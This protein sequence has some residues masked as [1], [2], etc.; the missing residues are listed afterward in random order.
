[1]HWTN[2]QLNILDFTL[3][4][5][6][7]RKGRNL[8]LFIVYTAVV[9][10]LASVM[11]FTHSIKQEAAVLLKNA[12][13][14]L[15]Q[16]V[17][18]GRHALVPTG[19]LEK[20]RGMRGV[21]TARGRLWGYYY[22]PVVGANYTLMVPDGDMGVGD[23]VP[24]PPEGGIII[25]NGISRSRPLLL[26]ERISLRTYDGKN[27]ALKVKDVLTP[28][29]ELVSADLILVSEED[30]RS[31]FGTPE[32]FV[33]DI[34]L[35]VRNKRELATI[36]G[37]VVDM[38]PDTRPITRDEIKRTYDAVFNWRGGMMAVVLFAAVLAFVIFA[39]DR[40]AGLSA[41]EKWEIGVLKATGWETS[42]VLLMKFWEGTV[43]SLSSFIAG[44]VL[45]YIHVFFA[46]SFL[47]EPA[48]KGWSTL[49]PDFSLVPCISPHQIFALFFL[50]VMPYTAVTIV[51]SW[52]AAT[53][54][55]DSIMRT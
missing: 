7:R 17:Q 44:V 32:G 1:M 49:Y 10:V 6:L 43:I 31:L 23:S 37:K 38:L 30:F 42:D 51:P 3:S 9:A 54:D 24:S 48:L 21:I 12:P 25:G 45:A 4:S 22:D 27:L 13:E 39:W 46:S 2:R 41:E 18:A 40:A 8:S 50:T 14:M 55:P 5:L 52:R 35:E 16:R 53:V 34:A 47:F 15:V 33:T 29:S 28:E 20:I 26:G 19:Y 11:F 36:A